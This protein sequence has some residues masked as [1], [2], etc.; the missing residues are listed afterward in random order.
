[1]HDFSVT[2]NPSYQA[3]LKTS[4]HEVIGPGGWVI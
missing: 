4:S 2:V 3:Q 1:M